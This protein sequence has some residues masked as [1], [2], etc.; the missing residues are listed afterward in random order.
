VTSTR[1][2]QQRAAARARLAREMAERQAAA[3]KRRQRVV[4]ASVAGAVVLVAAGTVGLILAVAGDDEITPLAEPT[5]EPGFVGEC[6]WIEVEPGSPG[7]ADLTEVGTP[8]PVLETPEGTGTLTM[9]TNRGEVSIEMDLAAV[10]CTSASFAHLAEVEFY[11]D[12]SCHRLVDENIYVL[13]CGDPTGTSSGGTTYKLAEE[14]LPTGQSPAYPK[15]S[16]A[17][18]KTNQPNSTGTQFFIVFEDTELPP[19]YTLLGM[20]TEGLDII[21]EVAAGGH[22]GAFEPTPGGG[23]PNEELVIETLAVTTPA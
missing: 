18:A 9:T 15:G 2:R 19:E 8:P 10:P 5:A 17:M 4:I 6:E 21:E 14:N 3:K 7:Y 22:D 11:N 12:T 16:V 1:E 20:V 13:Q 23:H